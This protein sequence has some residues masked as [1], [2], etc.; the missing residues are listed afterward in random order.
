MNIKKVVVIG[1]GTMG[2]ISQD[3][4][5]PVHWSRHPEQNIAQAIFVFQVRNCIFKMY[6]LLVLYHENE[7]GIP[8]DLGLV[9]KIER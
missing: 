2:R 5:V 1:S 8:N 3:E 7:Q 6:Y 4:N 9:Q